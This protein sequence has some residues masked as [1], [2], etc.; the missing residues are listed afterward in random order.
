MAHRPHPQGRSDLQPGSGLGVSPKVLLL[1]HTF[2]FPEGYASTIRARLFAKALVEAGAYVRVFCTRHS[3]RLPSV[4]NTETS[5]SY[6]G[7]EF[8]YTTGDTT[9]A[10]SFV[11]RRVSDGRGL[12]SALC[13][14]LRLRRAGE[15]DVVYLSSTAQHWSPL[16]ELYVSFL[17]TMRIPVVLELNELPWSQAARRKPIERVLSPLHGAA[18]VVVIS[19]YLERWSHSEAQR[20]R[21]EVPVF[22]LPILVDSDEVRDSVLPASRERPFVLFASQPGSGRSHLFGF[23]AEAMRRVWREGRD[24]DL[25]VLGPSRQDDRFSWL[26]EIETEKRHGSVV[27]LGNVPRQTLLGLY[28]Q[29][30]AL[31]L[32]MEDT[33]GDEARFPTKLGEYLASATP[34]VVSSVGEPYRFLKN[35]DTAYL[36]PAGNAEAF[37]KRV[38]DVLSDP[39]A[40]GVVGRKGRE[41]AL[42]EFDYRRHG[43]SLREWFVALTKSGRNS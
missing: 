22:R 36:A 24:C 39:V 20:L 14:I 40:A 33:L 21:R 15:L 27:W 3:D 11:Q 31:L 35:E 17:N 32:P 2:G 8:T 29:A 34:V 26:A 6:Q 9:R 41:L 1:T 16:T 7:I 28:Q 43:K 37:G 30:R 18:G 5:G 4:V 38:L 12:T 13:G 42:K 23:L 25:I 10:S 19:A